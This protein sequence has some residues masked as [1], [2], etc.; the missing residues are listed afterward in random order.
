MVQQSQC[1]EDRVQAVSSREG[2]V[3]RTPHRR[4]AVWYVH[5]RG[6]SLHVRP[7]VLTP[8][9]SFVLGI[10]IVLFFKCVVALLSPVRRRGEAIDW[11][12]VS[13]TTVMFS[14]ATV[15]T[16]M[17]LHL[18]SIS[19]IDNREFPAVDGSEPGPVGYIGSLYSD[20]INVI[21]NVA[22]CLN[23]WLADGFLV[24]SSPGVAFSRPSL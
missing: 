10:L 6:P 15:C 11:R 24:S 12:L 13:Y 2:L 4:D 22:L 20:A 16:A 21:P 19:Y 5:A 23:N 9:V 3:R 18:Q 7:P 14:L 1:S 8:F 17:N